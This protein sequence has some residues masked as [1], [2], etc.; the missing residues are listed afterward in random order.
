MRDFPG[1]LGLAPSHA[2]PYVSGRNLARSL[3]RAALL[4]E[5]AVIRITGGDAT[6][7]LQGLVTSDIESLGAGAPRFAALLTPQGKILFD[8]IVVAIAADEGGGFVLDA[9]RALERDLAERLGFYKLRAKVEVARR[10][11]LVVAVVLDGVPPADF[12]L[13]Y[14]DPRHRAHAGRADRLRACSTLVRRRGEDRRTRRGLRRL[15]RQWP[16]ACQGPPRPGRRGIGRE[17]A[18]LGGK[19]FDY[20]G[21]TRLGEISVSGGA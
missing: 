13:A 2:R 4:S 1:I 10:L 19:C 3:M 6:Q 7:F 21:E 18:A 16:R 9:P 11:D 17:R 12:G 14:P 8:F 20:A 5:R 15:D